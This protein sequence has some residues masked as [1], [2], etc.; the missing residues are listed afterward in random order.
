MSCDESLAENQ[1]A[2]HNTYVSMNRYSTPV[3]IVMRKFHLTKL[4]SISAD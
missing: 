3:G 4:S 2:R 1:I